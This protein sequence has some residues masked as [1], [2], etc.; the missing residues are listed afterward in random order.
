MVPHRTHV[1]LSFALA[2]AL[3]V[4]ALGV[5]GTR[6]VAADMAAQQGSAQSGDLAGSNRDT[7]TAV[8]RLWPG[9]T[10]LVPG[11]SVAYTVEYDT[12]PAVLP[13]LTWAS[14]DTSV[15][16]VDDKGTVSAVGP[17]E[18]TLSVR[19][20]SDPS[21]NTAV[22]II[23]R[24]VT[25]ER[26][27]E[28][29]AASLVSIAGEPFFLNALLAPSLH[30]GHVQWTLSPS[31]L[32]TIAPDEGAPT[33]VF[34]P[35]GSAGTG[36]LTAR[37]TTPAGQSKTMTIPV[38]VLAD[39]SGDFVMDESGELI[40]YRGTDTDVSIPE[41]VTA[42]GDRAF[43]EAT[44]R[45]VHIPASVRRI[46]NE[47]FYGSG[48]E[49]V[50]FQDDADVPSQL[51]ELGS[52]A[53]TH[54][55]VSALTLPRSLTTIDTNAFV[56]MVNLASIDL[57]PAVEQ[58]QLVGAFAS[59][60]ALGSIRVAAGNPHYESIDGVLY[61]E[62]RSHL[63]AFPAVKNAG[64]SYE[65]VSGTTDVD[66]L[67][68]LGAQVS[69]VAFP[70]TLRR[71]GKQAFEGAAL[72]SLTLPDA[73]ETMGASAFWQ[74]PKL[75]RVDLGGA[76][77]V[78]SNAFRYDAAL[79]DVTFR[80]DLGT[81]RTVDE[82]AFVGIS[83]P[84][85][86][87]P[88]TVSTVGVETFS[89]NGALAS[90]HVGASL[91]SMGD[92]ALGGD[93][94]LA[95]LS[96]SPANSSFFVEGGGLYHTD[97]SS[98]ALVRFAP[99]TPASAATVAPGTATIG[100]GA[101]E[102][103]A[104]L[105]RVT[106]PDGL[107]T[108]DDDAFSGCDKLTDMPI[109]D[110]VQVAR[111]LVGTGL[112]TID[113]GT[114]VRELSM[115]AHGQRFARHIIVRGGVNGSFHSAG[116]NT[117]DR[118][119]SA[120]F[121]DGMTSFSFQQEVPRVLV[122]P[123]SAEEVTL[124]ASMDEALKVDT[125]IYV[126]DVEGSSAWT[127]TQSAMEAAGYDASRLASLESPTLSLSGTGIAE[128]GE[129][130]VLTASLGASVSVDIAVSG[131]VPSGR[132]VR[133]V[134][135]GED[136]GETVL[137]DWSAMVASTDGRFATASYAWTPAPEDALVRVDARDATGLIRSVPTTVVVTH[138]LPPIALPVPNEE[139]DPA[140]EAKPAP[141]FDDEPSPVPSPEPAPS[142]EP[143]TS[144]ELAHHMGEWVWGARGWWY[145]YSDGSYPAGAAVT[146]AGQIYRFDAEGYMRVGWVFERGAWYFHQPSGAQ[147][148][149]WILDGV[150]WYYLA[151]GTGAMVTGWLQEGGSWYYLSETGGAMV[152]GWSKQGASWYYLTPGSGTMATGWVLS[153]VTWYRFS[154]SGQWVE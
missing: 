28:L 6:A 114:Q 67:A 5:T 136:G 14:S 62:D 134:R 65:V 121:G 24:A 154:E 39:A 8:L 54:T 11:Q 96:V 64:G 107:I 92:Y 95:T 105:E 110:S 137:Q 97:S 47:A 111:G 50:T 10:A 9:S 75:A 115:V 71:V 116:K 20:R 127:V 84:S 70:D 13:D 82:G 53:F 30:G 42:I 153:G 21:L 103:S 61:S 112:D 143:T 25:E 55:R 141:A 131:G 43:S 68:F 35:A 1:A 40:S 88:D 101:F 117:G 148:T 142:P 41:G 99:A 38:E 66:D 4:T 80:P 74:M 81:L 150:S 118:L 109:P 146:I 135:V 3:A 85:I 140:N 128:A 122:L 7:D 104:R 32:G 33:A 19:D 44:V 17:G 46:G 125:T 57:G 79:S 133:V 34:H 31:T 145:R 132:E 12:A 152:T 63:I 48:L 100:A 60:P 108:I 18:A 83:D 149:G 89:Q 73:F 76:T 124:A 56:D 129:G 87:L 16:T 144:P 98:Q 120:F 113:M 58:G 2:G 78:S 94:A 27:I 86:T 36:T 77:A 119:A 52:R 126:A 102:N 51:V 91:S 106:L 147:A 72:T 15:L 151:P 49:A 90:F 139:P 130:Y 37:V 45:T 59:T 93:D 23:V 69:S 26:G 138:V 123:S 22:P 29:S